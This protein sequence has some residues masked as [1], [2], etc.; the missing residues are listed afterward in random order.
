[1]IRNCPPKTN[2]KVPADKEN[3]GCNE[4]KFLIILSQPPETKGITPQWSFVLCFCLF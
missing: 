4:L 1:M 2:R 3:S